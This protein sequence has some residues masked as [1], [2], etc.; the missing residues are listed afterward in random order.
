MIAGWC[1]AKNSA[2]AGGPVPDEALK[3]SGVLAEL[4]EVHAAC[5]GVQEFGDAAGLSDE[6]LAANRRQLKQE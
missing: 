2:V 4:A 3:V 1:S 5:P 6:I